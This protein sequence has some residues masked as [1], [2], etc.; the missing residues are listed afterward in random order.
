[1]NINTAI[2]NNEQPKKLTDVVTLALYSVGIG[3][4]AVFG[5]MALLLVA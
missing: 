1:M 2:I 4:G 5:L 3:A